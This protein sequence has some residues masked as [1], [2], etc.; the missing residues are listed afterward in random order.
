V[1]NAEKLR[2]ELMSSTKTNIEILNSARLLY[3]DY[4][5]DSIEMI[6]EGGQSIV[7]EIKSKIDGE[8]YAA[9]KLQ[10]QI[11]SKLNS[12]K[13][14]AAAE[15]EIGCLRSFDHPMIMKMVDLVKAKDDHPCI[16]MEKCNQ[17]LANV[18]TGCTQMFL[19][20]KQVIR[21]LTMICI[22]LYHIH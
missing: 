18:I 22:P 9:K 14:I 4:D 3:D 1:T 7:F 6:K 11:G 16:I 13:I 15:R 2:Q 8:M 20:E 17:S 5:Y 21:I 19:P 10:Y 12:K